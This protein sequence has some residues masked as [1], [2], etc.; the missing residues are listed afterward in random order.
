[1]N[2]TTTATI[3]KAQSLCTLE[4]Q[5]V[6]VGAGWAVADAESVAAFDTWLNQFRATRVA[7]V[8]ALQAIAEFEDRGGRIDWPA[9]DADTGDDLGGERIDWWALPDGRCVGSSTTGVNYI[10]SADATPPVITDYTP[11]GDED[12]E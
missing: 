1:M 11:V 6:Y 9:A 8:E 7:V 2:A 12:D 10:V 3:D 5:S 4:L